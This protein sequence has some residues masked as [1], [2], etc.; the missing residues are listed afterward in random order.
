[1]FL[2]LQAQVPSI[3]QDATG[4]PVKGAIVLFLIA[5]F[6]VYPVSRIQKRDYNFLL[7]NTDLSF[8]SD[9]LMRDVPYLVVEQLALKL[10]PRGLN[11]WVRLAGQLNYSKEKVDYFGMDPENATQR[12]FNDWKTLNTSTAGVL[13]ERLKAMGRDDAA[14][15]LENLV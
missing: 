6:P 1:M 7:N 13:Y 14:E 4:S 8:S 2:S 15:V 12:M 3:F 5:T 9:I 10:N 11:N